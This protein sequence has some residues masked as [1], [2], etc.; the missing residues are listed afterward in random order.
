MNRHLRVSPVSGSVIGAGLSNPLGTAT[1]LMF[2][3]PLFDVG[4]A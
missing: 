4:D 2:W 3:I 1:W